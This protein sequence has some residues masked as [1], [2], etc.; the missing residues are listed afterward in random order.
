MIHLRKKLEV[1]MEF[2]GR[3]LIIVQN[4]PVPF[5]R[6]V[7]LEANTLNDAG[8]D[9]SIICPTGKKGEYQK[10]H[11]VINNIHI[12]RYPSPPEARNAFGYIFEFLYCWIFTAILSIKVWLKGKIDIIHACNPPDTFFLLALLY[13]PFGAKF[14]FD[15]HDLSPEMF[16]AKGGKKKGI[17][18][19]ALIWL[20]RMTFNTADVVI[21]TNQSYK[22]IAMQRGGV[23]S[24]DIFIVRNGPD[25][26]RLKK[27]DSELELKGGYPYLACYLGEM[28]EQD[29]VDY[30]LEAIKFFTSEIK[31]KDVKF[32]LMGGGPHIEA[33]IK[34]KEDLDLNGFVEFTGRVSDHDLCRYL[35][36]SDIC[37]DPDPYSEW[38]DKSTMNK[39][40]EYMAFGK[41]VIAFDLREN[42][43][44]AQEAAE[45]AT[46]N[47]IMEFASLIAN[48][49]DDPEKRQ[50]MGKIGYERAHKDLAWEYS[51]PHLLAAYQKTLS[52]MS[53]IER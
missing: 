35:S 3:V 40:M 31:R 45:Y 30:L 25:F 32:V 10:R 50:K 4:L 15:H 51:K 12:Y 44:S 1:I 19:R 22:D 11:E 39:I 16:L 53:T 47:D 2:V 9:V 49:L 38:A 28:C 8:Y 14:I 36:T 13:K 18:Y 5:D 7:W 6:R 17:L 27:V 23:H 46:P 33:L 43:Y 24:E 34:L 37:V 52:K 26:D 42:R 41:P 29:G 48:L 20:E 21:V